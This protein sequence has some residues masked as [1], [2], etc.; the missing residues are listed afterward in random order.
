[1]SN[2]LLEAQ[3][4][5]KAINADP[6]QNEVAAKSKLISQFEQF[7]S[8]ISALL[9][10]QGQERD[11][12]IEKLKSVVIELEEH[13]ILKSEYQMLQTSYQNQ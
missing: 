3:N 8:Q 13:E 7:S 11:Q 9:N 2:Q 12:I 6:L 1:L 4:K 5:L 10:A